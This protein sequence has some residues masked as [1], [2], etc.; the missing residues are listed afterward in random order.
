MGT[1]MG[2]IEVGYGDVIEISAYSRTWTET[3]SEMMMDMIY[4]HTITSDTQRVTVT[5]DTSISISF[6]HTSIWK[7][8][9]Q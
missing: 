4:E 2:I 1:S 9:A 8:V 6:T 7:G 5:S 3:V